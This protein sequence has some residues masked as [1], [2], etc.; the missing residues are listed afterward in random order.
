[1]L[2]ETQKDKWLVKITHN[3]YLRRP[4]DI[5][6]HTYLT[7]VSV[8]LDNST[9]ETKPDGVKAGIRYIR[10]KK[11]KEVNSKELTSLFE[12]FKQ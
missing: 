5:L 4:G 9:T 1:M 8:H 7:G 2:Y 6:P 11:F 10:A 3:D 12:W